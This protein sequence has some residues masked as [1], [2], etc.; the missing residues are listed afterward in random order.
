[1]EFLKSLASK[2]YAYAVRYPVAI[3]VTALLAIGAIFL[4]IGGF[5]PQ[6]GGI[7]GW[8]WGKKTSVT[9]DVRLIPP[10]DRKDSN[11]T[12]EP[13]QSDDKGFV[14][15]PIQVKI[16]EPGIFSDPNT[17]TITHPSRGREV[18]ELPTGVKNKDVSQVVEISPKVYQV[19]NDDSGVDA[20]KILDDLEKGK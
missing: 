7:I 11:G 13:G 4:S 2:L 3:A 6:I 10:P 9:P 17:I 1:M 16:E 20:G 19:R 18:V 15:A 12:I 8:L 5:R 14:Q